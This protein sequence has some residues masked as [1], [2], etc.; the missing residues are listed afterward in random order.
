MRAEV[1]KLIVGLLVWIMATSIT[2]DIGSHFKDYDAACF[3][4]LDVD[5][6]KWVRYND[7]RCAQQFSPCSTFKIPNSL[8]GLE[9]GVVKN[10]DDVTKWDGVKRPTWNPAWNQDHSMRSAFK[11]SVVWYYQKLARDVGMKDETDYVHKMHYGNEDTS[12]GVDKFWLADS[13]KISADQQCEFM[14]DFMLGKLPFSPENVAKVKEIMTISSDGIH[15]F[16]GKT[17][18]DSDPVTKKRNLNWFVGFATNGPHR[19]VFATNISGKDITGNSPAKRIT[20]DILGELG[21]L[22]KT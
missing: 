8:I 19:Y 7:K 12:G 10:V 17:G 14:R 6:G 4:L 5:S 18:S 1:M 11:E 2:A 13:L 3:A 22:P 20:R 21:V 9:T 15:S 16:G